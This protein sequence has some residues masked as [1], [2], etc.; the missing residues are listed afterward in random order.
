M[1]RDEG[2]S[3][4]KCDFDDDKMKDRKVNIGEAKEVII[5][6]ELKK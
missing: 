2:V 5:V 3:L 1:D 4:N 6:V